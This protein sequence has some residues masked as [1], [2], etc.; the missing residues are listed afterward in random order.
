M[1]SVAVGKEGR[2]G[3]GRQVSP[4]G[5]VGGSI[6]D[7]TRKGRLIYCSPTIKNAG[8]FQRV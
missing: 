5:H 8:V 6:K 3:W 2:G 4:R 1:E 7:S